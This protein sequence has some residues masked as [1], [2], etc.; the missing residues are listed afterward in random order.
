MSSN[1]ATLGLVAAGVGAGA[2]VAATRLNEKYMIWQDVSTGVRMLGLKRR[3]SALLRDGCTWVDVWAEAVAKHA[4]KPAISFEVSAAAA[5]LARRAH[6]TRPRRPRRAA[7]SPSATWTPC[8]T[9]SRSGCCPSAPG[10]GR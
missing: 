9:A 5:H 2:L 3:L 1:P 7:P 10:R 8:P 4:A 6:L